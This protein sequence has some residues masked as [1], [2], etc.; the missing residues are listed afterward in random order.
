[1]GYRRG[2][3]NGDGRVSMD[4]VSALSN[5]LVTNTGLDAYQLEAADMNGNGVVNM[6]DLTILICYLVTGQSL[7]MDELEELLNGGAQDC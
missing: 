3:V 1:M 4:D 7:S 2:D 6:D 5:Y